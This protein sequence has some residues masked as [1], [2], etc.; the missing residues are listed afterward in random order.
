MLRVQGEY[1]EMPG[2]CLT[3]EQAARLF[4]LERQSCERVLADCVRA[5]ILRESHGR[6]VRS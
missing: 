2:L 5:G 1:D 3:L 6:F 4:G